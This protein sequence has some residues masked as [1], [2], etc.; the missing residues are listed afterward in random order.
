MKRLALVIIAAVACATA[1]T[2]GG[3]CV[4]PLSNGAIGTA[5]YD[6]GDLGSATVRG[7]I[8]SVETAHGD[9]LLVTFGE[10]QPDTNYLVGYPLE[11]IASNVRL[12]QIAQKSVCS[13]ELEFFDADDNSTPPTVGMI[14]ITRL[15]N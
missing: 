10:C 7:I 15:P 11:S 9:D 8:G 2:H 3:Y 5:V 6:S 12:V 14:V 1:V 4:P 13:F